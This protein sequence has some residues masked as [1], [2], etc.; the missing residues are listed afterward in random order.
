M[1]RNG[2]QGY[3]LIT[4]VVAL[5]IV[6][7]IALLLNRTSSAGAHTQND[8]LQARGADYAALAGINHALWLANQSECSGDLVVPTT[9]LGV[10]SYDAFVTTP[11]G[12]G[13]SATTYTAGVTDDTYI[14]RATA[15]QN[16]GSAAQLETYYQFFTTNIRRS[17]YRF[18]I[19]SAGIPPGTQISSAVAKIYVVGIEA[20]NSVHEITADWDESTATWDSI[21]SDHNSATIASI[22][23]SSPAG[24]FV[25]VNI[26]ALV[27][28]WVN[29]AADNFGIMIKTTSIGSD[30]T[31]FA[32]K[33]F[34]D[35]SKHPYLEI[36]VGGSGLAGTSPATITATATHPNGASRTVVRNDVPIFNSKTKTSVILQPGAEGADSFIE[37]ESGHTTHNKADDKDLKI[38]SELDENYRPLLRFG[39]GAVPQGAKV[40]SAELQ[41]NLDSVSGDAETV[42]IHRLTRSWT[43]SGV[44]WESRDGSNGWTVPGGDFD[45]AV[46]GSFLA[47]SVG[48]VTADI[49]GLVQQWV[50]GS[51]ENYGLLLAAAAQS[52]TKNEKKFTSS[53]D[54]ADPSLHP[55][56]TVSYSCDCR[57]VCAA[58]QGSGDILLVV[59]NASDLDE[60]ERQRKTL[61]E[62]WGYTVALIT[63]SSS[64]SE[65]DSAIAGVDIVYVAE[66]ASA[67]S[68][69][70]KLDGSNSGV[71]SEKGSL[72]DEIG[73]ASSSTVAVGSQLDITDNSHYV[74]GLFPTGSLGVYSAPMQ[75]S[76]ASGTLATGLQGLGSWS[77]NSGLAVIDAGA[78]LHGGGTA[79]GRRALVPLG[80]HGNMDLRYLNANGRLLLQR[81]LEWSKGQACSAIAVMDR[82]IVNANDD[83][84]E[85]NGDGYVIFVSTDLELTEDFALAGDSQTI[86]LRF[87][88]LNIPQSTSIVDAQLL[89]TS[90]EADS[91]A[92]SLTI[93]G[94][95]SDDAAPFSSASYDV[96]GRPQTSAS[97][98]WSDV[99]PWLVADEAIES[100]DIAAIVQEV[101]DR[102]GWSSGNNLALIIDGTGKRTAHSYNGAPGSAPLLRITYCGAAA[103]SGPV[104]H[105]PMDEGA[106]SIA[107]DIIGGHDGALIGA[108]R[109]G[110]LFGGA[111]EFDGLN[112]HIEVP[113]NNDLSLS[114]EFT[115]T[116]WARLDSLNSGYGAVLVK[117]SNTPYEANY[118]FGV[119][120]DELTL[121]F[122]IDGS[123]YYH[124]ST[125]A[126][127]TADNWHHLAATFDDDTDSVVLY[128]DGAEVHEDSF[129]ETPRVNN[130]PL[131]I[132]RSAWPGEG[133]DGVL[134]EVR[135]Y[136]RA[137]SAA[138]IAALANEAPPAAAFGHWKLDDGTGSIAVDS[139]GG[140]DGVLVGNPS[141][142]GGSV[143]G[144]LRFDGSGDAVLLSGGSDWD[145]DPANDFSI[146]MWIRP[147]DL[148]GSWGSIW[149]QTDLSDRGLLI[150]AHSTGDGELGPIDNG[151]SV[152]W[153]NSNSD[154][155]ELH[156]V[157][158]V[159]SDGSWAHVVVTYDSTQ[160]QANRF[161]IY[162]DASD[163][164]DTGDVNSKGTLAPVSV[165]EA[166]F[167]GR[168]L[169]LDDWFRG[170][171]DDVRYFNYV[172]DQAEI[173]AL[174]ASGGGG[175]GGGS[176][177]TFRDEFNA[178]SYGGNDG[179]LNWSG[180]WHE[181]NESN[182][183]TS[184]DEQVRSDG[185]EDY[186]LRIRDNDGGGE[187]VYREADLSG[188]TAAVL[189]FDYRRDGL[190]NSN[191][192][193]ALDIAANG[194][195]SWNE[196]DRFAGPANENSYSSTSYDITDYISAVTQIRFLT[197]SSLGGSDELWVDNIQIDCL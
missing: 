185:G 34:A 88:N 141:W 50:S 7:S 193:I 44:T 117:A 1:K 190:D 94:E 40:H 19:A 8:E 165:D 128:V 179:S 158:D 63:D 130:A 75:G 28:S 81:S 156:S 69:G 96:T 48:F 87:R 161:R 53:D 149:A 184:G 155:L 95:A 14:D 22:P 181:I 29:G 90:A 86:G 23:S 135:I 133:W 18:D 157:D 39:L 98:D 115:L 152:G 105:W 144:A 21:E 122:L 138:D 147:E 54:D 175:G 65:Y 83:V 42:N 82:R 182:G 59:D 120:D 52:G 46:A 67:F 146:A 154:E 140:N 35:A 11:G 12:S 145:L 71:V 169:E 10:F 101:V 121:D 9:S 51:S 91:V 129:A 194:T 167:G 114:D 112:S 56:L 125:G 195:P 80:R 20:T 162:V 176:G 58:P 170:A 99:A 13:S 173:G 137:L 186:A 134:D 107:T 78:E 109:V 119:Y 103:A 64:Q 85:R 116:A 3:I 43:E 111:I 148:N 139:L 24:A 38:E 31:E 164:T 106:G 183:P 79:A 177:G 153:E 172:I 188:C 136:D 70:N 126:N 60:A 160:P 72:N 104:A 110:G 131:L 100:P 168:P 27:Q 73:F 76:A 5:F 174:A 142:S 33:E 108:T 143:D 151:I 41:L 123:W 159:L 192:Y 37:E 113:P 16:Y 36:T 47:E 6:A 30:L 55:R 178:R 77:G 132:G 171:L 66:S 187:G 2:Q 32:S 163:V 166:A 196:L 17:L 118:W 84:E 197:S 62:D 4:V 124:E 180:D 92:T 93:R 26:T 102:P 15:T 25:D 89:L 127:L 68:V 189:R 49:T 97:V 74:T 191:D 57:Y 150:Y 45:P 61:F